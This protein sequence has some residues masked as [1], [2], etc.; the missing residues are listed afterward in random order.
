MTKQIAYA[1]AFTVSAVVGAAAETPEERQACMNDANRLC[2]MMMP[3]RERVF[4]CLAQNRALLS[5][6]CR[7]AITAVLPPEPPPQ[8]PRPLP[9][10]AKGKPKGPL[11]LNPH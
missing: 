3:D 9:K 6:L 11:D 4:Q 5:P 2:A 7:T 1:V 8:T 10:G